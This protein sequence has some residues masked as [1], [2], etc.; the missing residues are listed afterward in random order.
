M[1]S[2]SVGKTLLSETHGTWCRYNV[3]SQLIDF[4]DWNKIYIVISK[5]ADY[6]HYYSGISIYIGNKSIDGL[7]ISET[8]YTIEQD[9]TDVK[10]ENNFVISCCNGG[11]LEIMQIYLTK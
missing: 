5:A 9:I 7:K 1:G 11:A 8:S 2:W 4:T 10:G 6:T 3:E